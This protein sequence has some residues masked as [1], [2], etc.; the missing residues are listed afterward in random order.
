MSEEWI[1]LNF[2]KIKK[3][4]KK[5]MMID[6]GDEILEGRYQVIKKLGNGAF[7]DIFRGNRS[8]NF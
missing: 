5:N 2:K 3:I 1:R 4:T 6:K 8:L 7:G